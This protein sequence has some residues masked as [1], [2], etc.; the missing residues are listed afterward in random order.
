MTARPIGNF[1]DRREF[2]LALSK[3]VIPIKI[4]AE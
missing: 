2:S 4:A 3:A 1:S